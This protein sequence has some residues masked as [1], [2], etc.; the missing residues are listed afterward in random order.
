MSICV[1]RLVCLQFCDIVCMYV[2]VDV[3]YHALI[4]IY[5]ATLSSNLSNFETST[6]FTVIGLQYKVMG[7]AVVTHT[8]LP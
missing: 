1:M 5:W 3:L 7:V 2:L 4:H 8:S 6:I